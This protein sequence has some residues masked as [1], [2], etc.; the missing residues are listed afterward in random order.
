MR[1][2]SVILAFVLLLLLVLATPALGQGFTETPG[3]AYVYPW[4]GDWWEVTAD[5]TEID[6]FWTPVD[7]NDPEG[8][9]LPPDSIPSTMDIWMAFTWVAPTR[10]L[11]KT[12]PAATLYKLDVNVVDWT[13]DPVVVGDLVYSV[14][15]YA[16]GKAFWSGIYI[17]PESWGFVPFNPRIGAKVYAIDWWAPVGKLA[18]G[19]YGVTICQKNTRTIT[20]LSLME[21]G[22]RKPLKTPKGEMEPVQSGF[23][24]AAP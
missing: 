18:P 15:T 6:H 21:Q 14:P 7:P 8:E 20:D 16:A 24:V 4:S 9:W 17:A 23:V 12:I 11:V 10:G 13:V 22:Q 2:L 3:N 5:G 1:R 19:M